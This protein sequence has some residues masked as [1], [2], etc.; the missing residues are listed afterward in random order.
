MFRSSRMPSARRAPNLHVGIW[1]RSLPE[2]CP[3][4]QRP[5]PLIAFSV[6]L[7]TPITAPDGTPPRPHC[8]RP[9]H[10]LISTVIAGESGH[11]AYP[12]VR[13]DPCCDSGLS[14]AQDLQVAQTCGGLCIGSGMVNFIQ[15]ARP[16]PGHPTGT[17]RGRSANTSGVTVAHQAVRGGVDRQRMGQA[18]R[19]SAGEPSKQGAHRGV[20]AQPEE[21]AGYGLRAARSREWLRDF[22]LCR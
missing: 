9:V 18:R 13:G 21:G 15:D 8:P 6:P 10:S 1:I 3:I 17:C 5:H 22:Q 14:T 16:H 11:V 7:Q 2:R 19:I 20:G 4:R 12:E